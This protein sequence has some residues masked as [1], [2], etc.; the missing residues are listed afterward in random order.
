MMRVC[1]LHLLWEC[2]LIFILDVRHFL[3]G[4]FRFVLV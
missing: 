1:F 3:L 2:I 4:D